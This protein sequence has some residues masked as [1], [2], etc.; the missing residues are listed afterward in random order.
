MRCT[1]IKR[2][3]KETQIQLN[4]NI[5]GFFGCE[6]SLWE[7]QR[8]ELQILGSVFFKEFMIS[9]KNSVALWKTILIFHLIS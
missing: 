2:E 8:N 3:T 5:D 9:T 7:R 4:L 1:E 6:L